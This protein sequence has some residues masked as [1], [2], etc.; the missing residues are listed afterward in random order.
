MTDKNTGYGVH[1]TVYTELSD[2]ALYSMYRGE[3]W[4]NMDENSRLELLQETVNRSAAHNG[5]IGACE[6][7]FSDLGSNTLGQ[8]SGNIIELNRF[9]FAEDKY[10]HEYNG[11]IIEEAVKDSNMLALETVLHEDIHAWQNQC[12]NGTVEYADSARF[13]EYEANNFSLSLISDGNG[14]YTVGS[15]YLNGTDPNLGY[16]FYYFQSTERDAHYYSQAQTLKIMASIEEKY[17]AEPSFAAYRQEIFLNGYEATLNEA[18]EKSGCK[19]FEAQVNQ[20]LMNQYHGTN[21][22]VDPKIEVLVQNEMTESYKEQMRLLQ[23]TKGEIQME[24]NYTPVTAEDYDKSMR[25][26]VN[27]YYE[28]AMSDPNM[29]KEEAMQETANMAEEY[30]SAMEEISAAQENGE[31]ESSAA[32]EAGEDIDNDGGVDD[33]GGI[34]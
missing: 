27:A 30:L 24:K 9:V 1:T 18:C 26:T 21:V 8:Q 25:E 14:G 5:E 17:G 3:V 22:P 13:S 12:L 20:V 4:F 31:I 2:D 6:V 15:H 19:D 10:I 16:Y 11:H 28:H 7:R 32:E 33:D 34:E 29:S 23:E